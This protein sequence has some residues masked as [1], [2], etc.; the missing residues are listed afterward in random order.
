MKFFFLSFALLLTFSCS[1][2]KSEESESKIINGRPVPVTSPAYNSA[3][4]L[5]LGGGL[6]TGSVIAPKIILTAA[7]CIHDVPKEVIRVNFDR[8]SPGNPERIGKVVRAKS[9]KSY[10]AERFP[11]FDIAYLELE[12]EVPAP[13][14]PIEILRDG[15]TL[16]SETPILLA[17]Y[18]NQMDNCQTSDCVGT[19]LETNTKFNRYYDEAHILSLLVFQGGKPLGLGGACNGDSGGPAYAQLGNKWYLVGVTNGLRGDIVPE[20]RDGSCE[21]G[22]NIYTFAGDYAPWLEQENSLS[23]S[24]EPAL[25]PKPEV[26]PQLQAGLLNKRKPT[27][28]GEWVRYANHDDPSWNTVDTLLQ[29]LIA[30]A[31]FSGLSSTSQITEMLYVPERTEAAVATQE[32]IMLS[33]QSIQDLSPLKGFLNLKELVLDATQVSDLSVLADSVELDFLR[34][35]G[36]GQS[37]NN[38]FLNSLGRSQA[39]L[40]VLNM[41]YVNADVINA[42]KWSNFPELEQVIFAKIDGVVDLSKVTTNAGQNLAFALRS[43]EVEGVLNGTGAKINHLQ[44]HYLSSVDGKDLKSQ[45]NWSG[46]PNLYFLDV[47]G[48]AANDLPDF[49][50]FALLKNLA[51]ANNGLVELANLSLPLG[52]ETLDV[53]GNRLGSLD[54]DLPGLKMLRAYDNPITDMTCKAENCETDAYILPKSL[55]EYCENAVLAA[56]KGYQHSYLNLLQSIQMQNTG[57][58]QLNCRILPQIAARMQF[59][60]LSG[61]GISDIRPLAYINQIQYLLL[62]DNEISDLS[63]I[64]GMARLEHLSISN[65]LLQEVPSF[66]NHYLLQNLNLTGNPLRSLRLDGMGLK[67]VAFGKD[68]GIRVRQNF[69]LRI[70]EAVELERLVFGGVELS[71]A[72]KEDLKISSQLKSLQLLD[73]QAIDSND[74]SSMLSLELTSPVLDLT[75]GC[76]IVNGACSKPSEVGAFEGVKGPMLGTTEGAR[77]DQGKKGETMKL[78]GLPS[79]III[80]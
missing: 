61:A 1:K 66:Q 7:H 12:K 79:A 56:A 17:G 3:V 41:E 49:S 68:T 5:D 31:N 20:A 54:L 80:K 75:D 19:L 46:L 28:W 69:E 35:R 60:Q 2:P 25:N 29:N 74:F 37:A 55:A 13:Y 57:W 32:L 16:G 33:G 6:C 72:S 4:R 15:N 24:H 23:L 44:L 40:R 30:T 34:V 50:S 11:N 62:D 67:Q 71:E 36:I 48:F 43:A 26:L 78:P 47:R 21:S 53:S 22:W 64:A 59:L 8:V 65:N 63:P 77:V 58:P 38:D 76:P 39:S 45:V 70:S 73:A 52:I 9:Y 27:S 51:L 18:G 14:S 42:M 10:G